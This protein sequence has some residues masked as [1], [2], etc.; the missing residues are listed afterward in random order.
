MPSPVILVSIQGSQ[1]E[2]TAFSENRLLSYT[3]L[4]FQ[5]I[6]PG[7]VSSH[8]PGCLRLNAKVGGGGEEDPNWAEFFPSHPSLLKARGHNSTNSKGPFHVSNSGGLRRY[9]MTSKGPKW[10]LGN[11]PQNGTQVPFINHEP[12]PTTKTNFK[13]DKHRAE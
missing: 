1:Q 6:L 8:W 13:K 3:T 10:L 12:S 4:N 7:A 2:F 9:K 5:T 11:Q